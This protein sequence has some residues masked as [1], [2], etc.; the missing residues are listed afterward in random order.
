MINVEQAIEQVCP[1]KPLGRAKMTDRLSE[2]HTGMSAVEEDTEESIELQGLGLNRSASKTSSA[3]EQTWHRQLAYMMVAGADLQEAAQQLGKT[4]EMCRVVR[5]QPWFHALVSRLADNAGRSAAQ[6]ILRGQVVASVIKLVNLRDG[7]A[8]EQVQF[9]ATKEL[10]DRY[11]GKP[12]QGDIVNDNASNLSV[13]EE[14]R[15][16]DRELEELE[17][18]LKVTGELP[19]SDS[20]S[21]LSVEKDTTLNF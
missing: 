17:A 15:L 19:T 20:T 14:A 8:S 9:N 1:Q 7:A 13:E 16:V 18:K 3:T 21:F 11:L 10:L 5:S 4:P 6:K 12:A 2:E